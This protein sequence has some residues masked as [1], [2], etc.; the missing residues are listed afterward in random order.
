MG[1]RFMA[2]IFVVG[3]LRMVEGRSV[4]FEGYVMCGIRFEP[5]VGSGRVLVGLGNAG[6]CT[7]GWRVVSA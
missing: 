4:Y 6:F 7:V 2:N 5:A 3:N 1:G